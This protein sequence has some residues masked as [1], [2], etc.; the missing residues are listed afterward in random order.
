M[1][2]ATPRV[3]FQGWI[4][5]DRAAE[6]FRAAGLDLEAMKRA[7]RRADFRPV[8]LKAS[9]KLDLAVRHEQVV[10]RNVLAKIT[11]AR[12]PGETVMLS[13]HWDAYGVGA[14]AKDGSTIRRGAADDAVGVAGLLEIGRALKTGPRPERTVL[15]AAWTG[16]ERGLLGSETYGA[17]PLYP[18]AAMAANLTMDVLQLAGPARDMVLVGKG[19]SSLDDLLGAAAA[20]QGRTITADAAPERG[21]FYRA[22]HF[23]LAKRG[24][25][26]LLL[27]GMGGGHD[28]VNGGRAAGDKWVSDYT[29][30][31]YHQTCDAW[32][33]Q[34]DFRGA[35]QDVEALLEMTK[36]LAFSRD[37]PSWSAGSE[38][39]AERDKTAAQRR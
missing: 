6:L 32:T 39:K 35:A 34:L 31:C 15:F 29:A 13:A 20:K 16:E 9:L 23:S 10:S 1:R 19:A 33:P 11:G 25:P 38:F 4:A 12:R 3:P 7:A 28:L 24:V 26:V 37:W 22:D 8:E 30:N 21:L 18:H 27:M 17:H 36:R 2:R 5:R 14:P